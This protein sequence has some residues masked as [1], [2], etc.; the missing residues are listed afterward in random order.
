MYVK[1]KYF[2]P[3]CW[4]TERIY[5]STQVDPLGISMLGKVKLKIQDKQTLNLKEENTTKMQETKK[6]S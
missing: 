2:N 5:Y 1:K 6:L 3:L 4:Y